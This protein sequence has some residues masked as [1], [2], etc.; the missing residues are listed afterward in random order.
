MPAAMRTGLILV[1]V[2]ES[3]FGKDVDQLVIWLA[4]CTKKRQ[5]ADIAAAKGHWRDYKRGKRQEVT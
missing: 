2:F 4:D 3:I 1:P 5:D